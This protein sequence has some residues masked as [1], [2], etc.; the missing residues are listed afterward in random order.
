MCECSDRKCICMELMYFC[1]KNLWTVFCCLMNQWWTTSLKVKAVTEKIEG[2][3][4]GSICDCCAQGKDT[5][6]SASQASEMN[7]FSL[8][9][10]WD[11]AFPE[12]PVVPCSDL[13]KG[14][15]PSNFRTL[16]YQLQGRF[17]KTNFH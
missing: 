6:G 3:M 12:C 4:P 16:K 7:Q 14:P 17:L 10:C 8:T 15:Q 5:T 11:R 1:N 13:A 2:S 9:L